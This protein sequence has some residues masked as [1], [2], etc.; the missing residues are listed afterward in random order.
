MQQSD[1]VLLFVMALLSFV[2]FDTP[3]LVAQG[4]QRRPENFNGARDISRRHAR[5]GKGARSNHR[6]AG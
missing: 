2:E 1:T 5:T 4:G 3:S 6:A